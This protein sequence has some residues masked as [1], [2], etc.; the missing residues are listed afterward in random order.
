MIAQPCCRGAMA[1]ALA[2]D[3]ADSFGEA[4]QIMKVSW[5]CQLAVVKTDL[6]HNKCDTIT[7]HNEM[8]MYLNVICENQVL[9]NWGI[10]KYQTAY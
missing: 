1:F 10:I 3:A 6:S 9:I 7:C 4:G 5:C 8:Q 2:I